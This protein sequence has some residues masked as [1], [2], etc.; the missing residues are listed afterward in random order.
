MELLTSAKITFLKNGCDDNKNKKFKKREK[1][2]K[3]YNCIDSKENWR[4]TFKK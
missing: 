3:I 1:K 4:D 2:K